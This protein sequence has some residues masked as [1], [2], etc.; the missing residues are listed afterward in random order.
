MIRL[1]KDNQRIA[2]FVVTP[3]L[4]ARQQSGPASFL[5]QQPGAKMLLI[6]LLIRLV[7]KYRKPDDEVIL[8]KSTANAVP[9][10]TNNFYRN[11]IIVNAEQRILR[12]HDECC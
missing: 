5:R 11:F 1:A 8:T 3:A 12:A 2:C 7:K 4:I 6:T 10:L 9:M